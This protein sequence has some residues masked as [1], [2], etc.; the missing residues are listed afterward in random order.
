L[1][2]QIANSLESVTFAYAVSQHNLLAHFGVKTRDCPEIPRR[3]YGRVGNRV[4]V[5]APLYGP[6]KIIDFF[7]EQELVVGDAKHVTPVTG[8]RFSLWQ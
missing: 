4:G 3:E 1:K 7:G 2:V 5:A 6:A 8:S